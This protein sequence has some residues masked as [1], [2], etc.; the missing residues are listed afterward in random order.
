MKKS[1][2]Q[3][4]AALASGALVGGVFVVALALKRGAELEARGAALQ[5]YLGNRGGEVELALT[6]GGAQM[7]KRLGEYA[8]T[9]ARKHLS[10][11]YGLTEA[12]IQRLVQRFG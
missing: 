6:I 4:G 10:D 9:A 12:R 8:Q 11:A 5:H 1:T 7:E 3:F 2:R